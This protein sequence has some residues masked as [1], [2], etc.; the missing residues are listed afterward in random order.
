MEKRRNLMVKIFRLCMMS[1]IV[2]I[3]LFSTV[4][5]AFC[6]RGRPIIL[7]G[8]LC[9]DN[10]APLRGDTPRVP[11]GAGTNSKAEWQYSKEHFN[12][13]TGRLLVYR[14]KRVEGKNMGAWK[15]SFSNWWRNHYFSKFAIDSYNRPF[16]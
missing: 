2:M 15:C 8:Q 3:M 5:N 13:N 9:A 6:K 10:G 16:R 7:N 4:S 11:V 14:D 12:F 1:A